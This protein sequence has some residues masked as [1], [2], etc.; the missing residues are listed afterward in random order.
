MPERNLVAVIDRILALVPEDAERGESIR[1]RLRAV[2][3]SAS[4]AAP[5][6]MGRLWERLGQVL[7]QELHTT[8]ASAWEDKIGRIVRGEE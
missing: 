4:F 1:N 7:T 2:R 6:A 5:E 8:A 3:E